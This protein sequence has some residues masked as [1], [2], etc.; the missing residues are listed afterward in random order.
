M[1]FVAAAWVIFA[2]LFYIAG[3]QELGSVG[4]Q[5]CRFG[6]LFCDK[7]IYLLVA[8]ALAVIWGAVVSVR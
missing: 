5:L 2:G 1:F 4:S 7:P 8:A 3:Q 6:D